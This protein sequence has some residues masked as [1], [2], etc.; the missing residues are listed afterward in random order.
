MG[1]SGSW[2]VGFPLYKGATLLVNRLAGLTECQT[3]QLS[4]QY[5]PK[6]PFDAGVPAQA[7]PGITAAVRADQREFIAVIRAATLA[8]TGAAGGAAG[9]GS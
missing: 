7:P 2:T 8:V 1:A 6:P 5:A 3:A 4:A 9:G